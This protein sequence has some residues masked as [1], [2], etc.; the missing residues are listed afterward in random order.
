MTTTRRVKRP[1]RRKAMM[2][3]RKRR[4]GSTPAEVAGS[5]GR[6]GTETGR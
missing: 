1:K 4:R 6:D 5:L 2:T 3:E